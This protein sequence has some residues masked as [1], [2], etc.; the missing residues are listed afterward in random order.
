MRGFFHI[1]R[2][3]RMPQ[4]ALAGP[5]YTDKFSCTGTHTRAGKGSGTDRVTGV[6][7]TDIQKAWI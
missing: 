7:S 4:E 1:G 2:S 5:T 3:S 6:I